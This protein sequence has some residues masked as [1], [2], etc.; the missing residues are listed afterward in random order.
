MSLLPYIQLRNVWKSFDNQL[1]LAGVSLDIHKGETL[2]ILGKSG[3]GKSVTLKLI[4]GLLEPDK[5]EILINGVNI[6]G[7]KED[8]L[9]QI[10][11]KVSYVFQQGALFDSLTLY[12][13]IAFPLYENEKY[14]FEE[15]NER[16]IE[17][18]KMLEVY[19]YIDK[20]PADVTLGVKKRVEIARAFATDPEAVLYDEPTTGLDPL[21]AKKISQLIRKLNQNNKLTSVVVTHDI[22]CIETVS[23]KI[24]L[25]NEGEILFYGTVD[26]LKNSD[27]PFIKEFLY[28]M[29][30]FEPEYIGE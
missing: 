28:G 6:V 22:S 19:E 1:V 23:D 24:A 16:V 20:Y 30:A 4:S 5:G 11:K 10:R 12:E 21:M 26:E 27:E 14:S 9:L 3:T 2:G 29:N 17:L 7:K 8:E 15:V 25:L 13:N 18:A